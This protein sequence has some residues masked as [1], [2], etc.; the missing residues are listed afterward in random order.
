MGYIEMVGYAMSEFKN[1]NKGE[2]RFFVMN[3]SGYIV[4]SRWGSK[5]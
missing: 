2:V 4:S 3:L 5:I 1:L